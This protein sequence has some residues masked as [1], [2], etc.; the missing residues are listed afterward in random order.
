[1]T[2]R[3]LRVEGADGEFLGIIVC[4]DDEAYEAAIK[5]LRQMDL[6]RN[7]PGDLPTLEELRKDK[8]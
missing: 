3:L 8:P 2:V 7:Q 4:N 6:P 1:M 5:Q